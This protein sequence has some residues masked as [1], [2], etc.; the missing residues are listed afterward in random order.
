MTANFGA[1]DYATISGLRNSVT[2]ET[3][4]AGGGRSR[5]ILRLDRV[6]W[7]PARLSRRARAAERMKVRAFVDHLAGASGS[8]PTGMQASSSSRNLRARGGRDGAGVTDAFE[9]FDLAGVNA[10]A[11]LEND[12]DPHPSHAATVRCAVEDFLA[13]DGISI[14]DYALFRQARVKGE[15][16][17]KNQADRVEILLAASIG[18][19]ALN[20]SSDPTQLGVRVRLS[21]GV[22]R[23]FGGAAL[24]GLA[25]GPIGLRARDFTSTHHAVC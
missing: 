18:G 7:P 11:G 4:R 24:R 5:R 22:G 19:R 21:R 6:T 14:R 15:R 9:Q 20:K 23:E 13:S 3:Y 12:G 8:R 16:E 10:S 17:C 25:C 1:A 2:L